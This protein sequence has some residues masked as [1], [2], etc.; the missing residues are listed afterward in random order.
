MKSPKQPFTMLQKCAK[1]KRVTVI[2]KSEPKTSEG[3]TPVQAK[4]AN[5]SRMMTLMEQMPTAGLSFRFRFQFQFRTR[6][7]F[8]FQFEARLNGNGKRVRSYRAKLR[9]LLYS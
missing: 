5:F 3:K 6:S 9:D 1:K 4:C 2:T 7:Q 8:Q